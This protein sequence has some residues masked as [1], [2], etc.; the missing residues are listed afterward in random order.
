MR[1][2]LSVLIVLIFVGAAFFVFSG[3]TD[4]YDIGEEEPAASF[5]FVPIITTLDFVVNIPDANLR[6]A[7]HAATGVP[8]GNNIVSGDLSALTGNLILNNKSIANIEGIQYCSNITGLYLERN[9]ISTL[10]TNMAGLASLEQL[11]L[12]SNNLTFAQ[13]ALSSMPNL[14]YVTLADNPI[15]AVDISVAFM[16]NLKSLRLNDCAFASYP[17]EVTNPGLEYLYLANNNI[18]SVPGN[19]STMTSLKVLDLA[20][21]GLST[22][23]PQ[24]YNMSTI[25]TLHLSNNNISSLSSDIGNMTGLKWLTIAGNKLEHLPNEIATLPSITNVDVS[26]N[27]LYDLPS[28]IGVVDALY[29][30]GNRI[31]QLPSSVANS[32]AD[33]YDLDMFMNR[34]AELP[35]NFGDNDYDFCNIEF[36]FLDVSPGSPDRIKIDAISSAA[37]DWERQ[38]MPVTNLV[39]MASDT[40]ITLMWDECIGGSENGANW[41]VDSYIVYLHD[42]SLVKLADLTPAD[43][44]YTHVGLSPTESHEYWVGVTYRLVYPARAIDSKHTGY[45]EIVA[46]TTATTTATP[47]ASATDSAMAQEQTAPPEEM[48]EEELAEQEAANGIEHD[49]DT[50]PSTFP[51]WAIIL[52]SILGTAGL[53]AGAFFGIKALKGRTP[54]PPKPP[55]GGGSDRSAQL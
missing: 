34:M 38:F 33:T 51:T 14:M 48:S 5:S 21:T 50:E 25:E 26:N 46:E 52:I 44:T 22:V 42:G 29:A 16:P 30:R 3:F 43:L 10:L 53:G 39:A 27:K 24:I 32:S 1:K 55:K 4:T 9:N 31:D 35:N 28:N 15:T 18:G 8:P 17:L 13:A 7:L 36:N 19:V 37:F 45:A 41:S 40:E 11:S 6:A 49:L 2:I 47:Q 23:T 12:K 20:N 54:K